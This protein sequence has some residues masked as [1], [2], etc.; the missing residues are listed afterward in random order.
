MK[1]IVYLFFIVCF[2]LN[3]C[4]D[5][6]IN[7]STKQANAA[8][9]KSPRRGEVLFLGNVGKHHDSG[10][11]APW[12]AI[13]LFE[14]GI[15]MTYTTELTDLNP[16]NLAKYDGLVIYSNHDEIAPAQEAALKEFVE[17]GKGLIALHSAAGCFRNS[18]WYINAVG[19]AYQ[20]ETT[21]S[22][23]GKIIKADHPVMKGINEFQTI[24]EQYVHQKLNPDKTV[25]MERI[26]GDKHE[27]YTWV[28]NQGK[29]RVFYTAYGH[30][31]TTWKRLD[32]L[33]LVKNGTLWAIGDDV[34]DQIARLQIPKVDIYPDTIANYIERHLVPKMQ[35][36]LSPKESAKMMQVPPGFDISLFAAEPDITNPIAMA[37]D[38]RGRL[39]I[40]ESVDYPN[41]FLETDGA[42]NDR[43]KI[44]EDTDGDGRADKF[45]IF[46]D[47]L[48]IPTSMVFAN[49]GVIVA[50]APHFLFLKDTNGDDKAD[51]RETLITG[52]EKRDTHFGPSQLQYGFNNKIWGVVGSSY[53]GLAKEDGHPINFRSG[54]YNMNPNGTGLEFLANT[55]NNTWGLGFSEDNN[56]FISTA[57][58]THS[59]FYSMPAKY[60]QRELPGT[61]VLPV[62]K[63]D[64]HYDVHAMQPNLRQVDVVGGFTAAAGHR[65]YTARV[66][67]KEY[68]NR[69]AF[70]C[71]P[72]VRLIHNAIIEPKGAGFTEKDGWNVLASNDEWMS[73]VQAEVGP[74]GAVWFCDWY[75]FIIQH[76]VFVERQAPSNKVLPFTDQPMGQGNAFQSSLRDNNFGRIYRITYKG[77]KAS[78]MLKLSKTDIPGLIAAL[79]N[80]NMFWR[81]T[82]Q[83]LLVEAKDMSAVPALIKLVN[84]QS[85]DA[86]GLNNAA[87]HALWTLNGLGALN[88]NNAAATQAAVGA[89]THHAAG[90][91]KAAI[92]TLPKNTALQNLLLNG[93]I[94]IDPALNVR[95]S[96]FLAAAALPPS[97]EMGKALY[98]A[99]LKGDNSKDEWLSRAIFAGAI[100]HR[101]GFLEAA[102]KEESTAPTVSSADVSLSERITNAI[103]KEIYTIA[104]NNSIVLAP[105]VSNKEIIVTTAIAKTFTDLAGV[106]AAQGDK[107]NGYAV[108]I[109]DGKLSM[110]IKQ[111]GKS[112]LATTSKPLPER[113]NLEASLTGN[114]LISIKI[115]DA[116]VAKGKAPGLFKA[117]LGQAVRTGTDLK[118]QYKV[119]DYPDAP[120]FAG[121]IQRTI[122]E[123]RKPVATSA[124]TTI[125]KGTTAKPGA[126]LPPVTISI[127]VVKDM[128]QFT[129]KQFT[130]K[131]GQ[132]VI[133]EFENPD[134][135]QHN[136][137][138]VKP[139]TMN[140]VGA[141]VD[142]M[143]QDPKGASKSYIPASPDVFQALK[144]I[145]SGD[146]ATLEFIAP[147]KPGDYPYICTFPGHWRIMNGV[148]RVTK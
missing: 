5:K 98:T 1:K 141:A 133:I 145:D 135:M 142:A 137:V 37:W 15:N 36:S 23:K 14:A 33:N 80:D 42:A 61:S 68:W 6:I 73:P 29:G 40:V 48:N 105:N 114:G 69:I 88:G 17:G 66:F 106:V 38:E 34:K 128:M 2:T 139:G 132:K 134:G 119:G 121:N 16:E 94:M 70:I 136:I 118:G 60:M 35:E 109:Q 102:P 92:E 143:I 129:K 45:T 24:D 113:F 87:V 89:L 86:I 74:D 47:K 147:E 12:L 43:I 77:G 11:Y 53:T 127:K 19:G 72:T 93:N 4:A 28:R 58:N 124:K 79:S 117:P 110:L 112:Y 144:L 13:K 76:N 104:R 32:F 52:W 138:I 9:S 27:P 44:C 108:Y 67:P 54:M 126:A 22:F 63:I 62:E 115:D 39:W 31:D 75:N 65:L 130:V 83:R 122:V 101:E 146:S 96:A 7:N 131:A 56:V 55:S 97:E 81:M 26:D 41:T 18:E 71:E 78:T 64:G 82:A 95:L 8:N 10:K 84:D 90:V 116:E 46:A 21:G 99:S 140:K 57:N 123:L 103:R 148:M 20:S 120:R 51:V 50:M 91:R 49:G 3:S 100:V 107:T 125:V 111:A 30:T 59:A 85:V 25:L